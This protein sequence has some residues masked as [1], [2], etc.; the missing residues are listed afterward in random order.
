MAVI[1]YERIGLTDRVYARS[2]GLATRG[3]SE[4]AVNEL[5]FLSNGDAHLL[6]QVQ[7]RLELL[8]AENPGAL[9]PEGALRLVTDALLRAIAAA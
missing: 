4:G 3:T 6:G 1:Q 9:G 5:M 2:I 7:Y 8:T